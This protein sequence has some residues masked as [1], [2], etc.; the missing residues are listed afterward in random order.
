MFL[1]INVNIHFSKYFFIKNTLK[2]NRWEIYGEDIVADNKISFSNRSQ[3]LMIKDTLVSN[4]NRYTCVVSNVVG[5]ASK[6]ID[7]IVHG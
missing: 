3:T 5:R 7:L 1:L 6:D 4:A 2:T